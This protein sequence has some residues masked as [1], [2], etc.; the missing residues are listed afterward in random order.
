[1]DL[2]GTYSS[3]ESEGGSDSDC[4]DVDKRAPSPAGEFIPLP[5]I[6]IGDDGKGTVG[7]TID[8]K[9]SV[10][11]HEYV[12]AREEKTAVLEQHVAMTNSEYSSVDTQGKKLCWQFRKHG[13][14]R[15]GHKCKFAHDSDLFGEVEG[16][17]K[18]EGEK[19]NMFYTN[20][21][22]NYHQTHDIPED[23]E[24]DQ[25][26]RKKRKGPGLGDTI[27]PSAKVITIYKDHKKRDR[28]W[29]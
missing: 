20:K 23:E 1:M 2:L 13:R 19:Q 26:K 17:V 4:S 9:V 29:K 21:I 7:A 6:A 14:C 3:S 18:T 11:R 5:D 22:H 15:Q 27:T 24:E 28:S 16:A 8:P 12:A 10:F 25:M